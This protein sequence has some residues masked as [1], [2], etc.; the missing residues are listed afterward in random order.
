MSAADVSPV[1]RY[2]TAGVA[3]ALAG[4]IAFLRFSGAV[5]M[6]PRPPPPDTSAIDTGATLATATASESAWRSFLEQDARAAGVPTPSA[7]QMNR[8]LVFR[9]DATARLLGPGDAPLEVAGLRLEVKAVADDDGPGRLLVLTIT[10]LADHDLGYQIVAAAQPGG[11]GCNTR[12]V[13]MHDAMVVGRRASVERS[14]CGYA[15]GMK[16][17]IA[18]V[19]TVEVEGLQS[20]YLSRVPPSAVG[21]DPAITKAHRPHLPSGMAPCNLGMSQVLRSAL[22]ERSVGWRDLVDFY[23]RHRCDSYQFS[24]EYRAFT[25]PGERP[26]PAGSE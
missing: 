23:A 2:G 3:V 10:N 13:L 16:L 15:D 19:E 14:E 26:L 11:P 17:A 24:M 5:P 25:K 9:T 4:A 1:F 22:E 18:R 20:V 21:G 6:P 12:T 8:P 7:E